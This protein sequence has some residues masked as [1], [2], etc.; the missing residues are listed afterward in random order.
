VQIQQQQHLAHLRGL[1]RPC[2]QDLRREPL[3]LTGI[4]VEALI[5]DPRRGDLDG[6]SRS[7]HLAV[8]VI[9][10]TD[11]QPAT[12]LIALISELLHIGGDLSLQRRG[13]HLPGT[14]ANNLIQQ[15][16]AGL[17]AVGFLG[18]VNYREHGRTFPTS[19]STPVLIET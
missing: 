15:R 17:A 5:V 4:G 12:I 3:P 10:V 1:A 8:L 16:P 9:P 7:Q 11:H 18:I 19:A 6:P 2:R 13:Q 14:I